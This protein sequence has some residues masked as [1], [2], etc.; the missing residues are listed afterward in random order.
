MKYFLLLLAICG[1]F[2]C[3][4]ND[5]KY[6][7][8]SYYYGAQ[9]DSVLASIIT[10]IFIAPPYTEMKDRFKPEHRGFYADPVTLS[11]FS[12]DQFY[13]D[14]AGT[15]YFLVL[16]PGVKIGEKRAVGGHFK[17]DRNFQFSD[18]R[19]IFVTPVLPEDEVKKKGEFLFDKMV[20]GEVKEFLKMKNYV[21]W[22]N[23][24]SYYDS[25]KYEWVLDR[26]ML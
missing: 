11:K 15:N 3:S 4:L 17:T 12:I 22:P 10:Y 7:T 9:Q 13:V 20:K 25:T 21:Q 5:K 23:A 26:G 18:F 19:E 8:A 1:L 16:R 14:E 2:G 24:A 6:D